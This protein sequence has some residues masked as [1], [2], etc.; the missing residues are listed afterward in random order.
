MVFQSQMQVQIN[1]F[2]NL[3]RQSRMSKCY[4]QSSVS[5]STRK[6][7]TLKRLQIVKQIEDDPAAGLTVI[8]LKLFIP[9]G[10]CVKGRKAV[11]KRVYNR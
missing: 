8:Q 5:D 4:N 10:I 2:S 9:L 6:C 1:E 3:Y 7:V 11:I